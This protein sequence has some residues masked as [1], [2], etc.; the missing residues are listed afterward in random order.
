MEFKNLLLHLFV[1]TGCKPPLAHVIERP[2]LVGFVVAEFCLWSARRRRCKF[3]VSEVYTWTEGLRRTC[4]VYE[5]SR[6]WVTNEQGSRPVATS[7]RSCRHNR[8]LQETQIWN[9]ENMHYK[10]PQL[11]TMFPLLLGQQQLHLL[12]IPSLVHFFTS[13]LVLPI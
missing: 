11:T 3:T 7:S 4:S 1:L 6:A 8:Y 13:S 12:P 9:R 2:R 5:P 10:S